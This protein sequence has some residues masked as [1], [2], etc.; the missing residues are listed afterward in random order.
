M[1]G[2]EQDSSRSANLYKRE[3]G[4]TNG[5]IDAARYGVRSSNGTI[6][7]VR[8]DGLGQKEVLRSASTVRTIPVSPITM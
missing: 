8:A 1:A 2:M 7:V 3:D 4:E 5:G 6:R